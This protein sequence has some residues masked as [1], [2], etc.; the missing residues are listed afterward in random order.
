MEN[1]NDVLSS[2]Q[3]FRSENVGPRTFDSLVK[4]HGSAR[5]ALEAIPQMAAKGGRKKP[6]KIF[7][8]SDA[9]KEIDSCAK[10]GA[11][12]MVSSDPK[13]P[14]LLKEVPD[15][16]PVI[17]IYGRDD[18][19]NE[20]I[21]G[22]VGARN[23]SANG[24]NFTK[25]L[26]KDLGSHGL[27][28]ASGLARGVDTNAH[29]GSLKTGTIAVV[30]GGVDKIYPP[31]N[32]ELFHK[33]KE[34]GCVITE[35]PFGSAPKAQNFPRRNRI[36]SGMSLGVIVIEANLKS[37]SLITA[38]MAL[39]QGREV[40]SVPGSPLDPRCAGT[41]SL[42]KQGA[43]LIESAN[44]VMEVLNDIIE[45]RGKLALFER[46]DGKFIQATAKPILENDLARVRPII[47][48]KL[49][50]TPTCVDDIISQTQI[51]PN[52]VWT[53]ILELELAGKLVRNIGNKVSLVFNEIGFF[54]EAI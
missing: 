17:T 54:D 35:F 9:E 14:K 13:Y 18:V 39:E 15:H 29:E 53:V 37:G 45:N 44:D 30:A 47:L 42:I 46:A 52:I 31:E 34:G 6:I 26:A 2:L 3:L 33:I 23:A 24:C 48:E 27:V 16:P 41:N 43:T 50:C 36:I 51:S 20:N 38:K 21:V 7:S 5:K 40:F 22:I 10:I 19:F 11:R 32:R 8:A 28:V 4:L 1:E 49:S 12:I 25:I